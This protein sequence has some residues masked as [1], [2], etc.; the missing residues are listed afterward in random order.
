MYDSLLIHSSTE[1]Y[2]S[3]F[4]VLAIKNGSAINNCGQIF[5][6]TS[7]FSSFEYIPG[8]EIDGFYGENMF[9]FVKKLPN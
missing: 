3:C 6:C 1:E 5:A 9:S 7:V 2:L 8:R 4:Q